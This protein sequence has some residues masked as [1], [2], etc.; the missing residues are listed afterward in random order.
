VNPRQ[1]GMFVQHNLLER[2]PARNDNIVCLQ[3]LE[4]VADPYVAFNNL[5]QSANDVLIV[6]ASCRNRRPDENHLWSFDERDFSEVDSR[7][8][9]GQGGLN[10]FWLVDK[11]QGGYLFH[12][13][14]LRLKRIFRRLKSMI[15]NLIK[16]SYFKDHTPELAWIN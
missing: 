8:T 1:N 14:Q 2:L 16:C 11:G 7:W 5:Y 15:P 6:F 12:R 4:H 13:P 10:I 9:L 3:S